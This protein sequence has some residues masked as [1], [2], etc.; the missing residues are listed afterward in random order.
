MKNSLLG[1]TIT[2]WQSGQETIRQHRYGVIET[3]AGKLVAIHL[4]P[5]PKL[6]AW[7]EILPVG[8]AYHVRGQADHCFLYYN[9][10]RRCPNFLALKYV[11]STQGTPY[12][13]FC[14]AL[15]TLD[16]I[17]QLKQSDALLCDAFNKRL[18]DRLLKR[19][20]WEPHKPQRW[21]RNFIKRFY[22]EYPGVY[23]GVAS[24]W[25]IGFPSNPETEKHVQLQ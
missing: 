22:G 21:H 8:P 15:A 6:L 18:S 5:W 14:V 12:A 3:A 7:P 1:Q 24:P 2:D 25:P 9:Q 13:T 11:V 17:A 16:A 20:D 10:P 19:H 23:S 4:R